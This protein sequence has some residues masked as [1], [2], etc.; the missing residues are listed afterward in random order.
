M[1]FLDIVLATHDALF[2]VLSGS[3]LV[4]TTLAEQTS[5][6]LALHRFIHDLETDPT[7]DQVVNVLELFVSNLFNGR[8]STRKYLLRVVLRS[9]TSHHF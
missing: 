2:S 7:P 5:A 3:V 4:D 6:L 1:S 8:E 9:G